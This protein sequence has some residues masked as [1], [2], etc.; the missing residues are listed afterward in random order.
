MIRFRPLLKFAWLVFV[1]L[2]RSTINVAIEIATP[3][4]GTEEVIVAV[5]LPATGSEHMLLLSASI[6]SVRARRSS[7]STAPRAA[8]TSTCSTAA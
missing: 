4:D 5:D 3:N 8:T 6:T 2:A 1:D 7:T